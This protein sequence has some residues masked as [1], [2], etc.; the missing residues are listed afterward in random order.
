MPMKK[1]NESGLSTPESITLPMQL[2]RTEKNFGHD[3]SFPIQ[4]SLRYVI[5]PIVRIELSVF[6]AAN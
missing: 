6:P 3:L 1:L 4:S 2:R 5:D